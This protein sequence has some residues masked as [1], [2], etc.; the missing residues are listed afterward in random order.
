MSGNVLSVKIRHRVGFVPLAVDF[1]L[2]QPWTVLFGPSGSGKTTLLR[3]IAGLVR[4]EQGHIVLGN[5]VLVDTAARVFIPAHLRP[6]RSAPQAAWLFPHLSVIENLL[7]GRGGSSQHHVRIAEEMMELFQLEHISERMPKLLSGGERQRVSV[8]R[9]VVS[10]VTFTGPEPALL[11][12]DEPFSG[13]DLA[14]R[15]ELLTQLKVWL[16]RR[17][18]P[19]LSVTHDVG[20]AFQLEAEVIRIAEGKVVAQGPAITVLAEEQRLLVEQLGRGVFKD[21]KPL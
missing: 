5:T 20:E 10:A 3:S 12:L 1:S 18:I 2:T 8:A 16:D 15:D 9:A 6:V 13:L 11:L 4:L 17:Q 21:Q 19:V 7:Y 14:L